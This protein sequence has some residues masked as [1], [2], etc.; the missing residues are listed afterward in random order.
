MKERERR[1]EDRKMEVVL[2]MPQENSA[3]SH[4]Y[5]WLNFN[6]YFLFFLSGKNKKGDYPCLLENK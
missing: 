6:I 3:L 4:Y 5:S 2:T 1:G